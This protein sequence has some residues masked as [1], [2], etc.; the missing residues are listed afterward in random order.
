MKVYQ[1]RNRQRLGQGFE[2]T[3]KAFHL[4]NVRTGELFGDGEQFNLNK[5]SSEEA[6]DEFYAIGV[7]I[8]SNQK[9]IPR[10]MEKYM[11]S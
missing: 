7:V 5:L 10:V 4:K 6:R 9:P 2:A 11:S 8:R 1:F 3:S